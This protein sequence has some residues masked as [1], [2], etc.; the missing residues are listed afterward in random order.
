M[1][2]TALPGKTAE[3]MVSGTPI[4]VHAPPYAYISRYA[5]EAGWGYVVDSPDPDRL[6][7]AIRRLLSDFSL[8]TRLTEAAYREASANL[9]LSLI[10][11][12]YAEYFG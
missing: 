12:R 2:R 1:I 6:A 11:A 4:L 3:Y 10:A 5:R 8:R 9:D 7:E